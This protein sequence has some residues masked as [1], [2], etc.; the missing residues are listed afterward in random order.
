MMDLFRKLLDCEC[1]PGGIKC[2]C[3]KSRDK[4]GRKKDRK[5]ER[6]VRRQLKQRDKDVFDQETEE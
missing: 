3:C 4:N 5:L 2:P 1:G 6:K